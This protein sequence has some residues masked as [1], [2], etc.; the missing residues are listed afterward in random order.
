MTLLGFLGF[1]AVGFTIF[2]A[3]GGGAL[4]II[5]GRYGGRKISKKIQKSGILNEFDI[6][7]VRMQCVMKWVFNLCVFV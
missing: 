7:K 4:G 6:F 2:G 3:I 1:V 5:L